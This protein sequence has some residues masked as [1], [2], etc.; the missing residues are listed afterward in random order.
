[1]RA[2]HRSVE[3]GALQL[4]EH[5]LYAARTIP[6]AVPAFVTFRFT[7]ILRGYVAQPILQAAGYRLGFT[8]ATVFQER[9]EH[10]LMRDFKDEGPF[11]LHARKCMATVVAAVRA[12]SSITDNLLTAYKALHAEGIVP[13]RRTPPA[14]GMDRRCVQPRLTV[15]H[16]NI[17]VISEVPIGAPN[18]FG[19]TLKNLFTGWP[20]ERIRYFYN[21]AQYRDLPKEGLDFRFAPVPSSPGR[22][23]ALPMWLGLTPE[24]RGN[25]SGIWLRRNV[26]GFAPD[27]V[28]SSVH[29]L[30]TISFADWVA[31]QLGQ[32]HVLHVMDEPFFHAEPALVDA[33]LQRVRGF[34]T[35]SE[36][37]RRAYLNATAEIPGIPQW[38]RAGVANPPART[39]SDSER[40]VRLRFMGNLLHLQHFQSI[41][42]IAA[43]MRQRNR[44]GGRPAVLEIYG[45]E[46]P[47]GCC[48]KSW[49]VAKSPITDALT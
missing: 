8:C 42:D 19:V 12:K 21:D 24:W 26:R 48:G 49:P 36:T 10:D 41:E 34:F 25:Y 7:D 31:Q 20:R 37:M 27:L 30:T 46:Y 9:N 43:A 32:P 5:P 6:T 33:M 40:P 3:A 18:G 2:A 4:P 1:M 38:C 22:R 16:P 39:A 28:F 14:G 29:S 35:I 11:Y 44:G 15:S 45:G 47:E 17:P 23:C 13:E